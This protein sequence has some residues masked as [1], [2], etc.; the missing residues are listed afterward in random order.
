MKIISLF[1]FTYLFLITSSQRLQLLK[2]D[3][4]WAEFKFMF[5][6]SFD[7]QH[8]EL[9]KSKN[10]FLTINQILEHNL[11]YEK[12]QTTYNMTINK[13]ADDDRLIKSKLMHKKVREP[14]LKASKFGLSEKLGN[15]MPQEFD[16]RNFNFSTPVRNQGECGSCWAITVS[17]ALEAQN[18]WYNNENIPLSPQEL[19][20]CSKEDNGCNGGWFETAFSYISNKA[21]QWLTDEDTYSYQDTQNVCNINNKNYCI[22]RTGPYQLRCLGSKP[23]PTD[24]E[25]ALLDALVL[26]GP[27]PVAIHVTPNLYMYDTGVFQDTTCSKAGLNHAVLLVGY[28]MDKKTGLKYWTIKNSWGPDWGEAGYFRIERGR[29]MCG[30]AS[31]AV[32]PTIEAYKK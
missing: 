7:N 18:L 30:I 8:V 6:R 21:D 20:D 13:F 25:E 4:L 15:A 9:V 23:L 22:P 27:I 32:I 16:W 10:F 26:S 28:G 2:P 11:Q 12:N 5:N 24:D 14:I 3:K 1:F 29:N 31:Y 17:G 19:V